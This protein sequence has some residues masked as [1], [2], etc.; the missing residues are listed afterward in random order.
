MALLVVTG[1]GG[2]IGRHFV[3]WCRSRG[4][5]LRT[6]GRAELATDTRDLY[7]GAAAVVH[8]AGRAHV[9]D[10]RE[11]D[12]AAAFRAVNLELTQRVF[13][14]SCAA[15]VRRFVYISS[16]G[17]LGNVSPTG[18]FG[19]DSPPAPYDYYSRSKYEAETWLLAQSASDV[20][21]VILRPPLVHGPGAGGNFGRL[22]RAA[23]RGIPLPTGALHARR[24]MIG[25]RNLCDITLTAAL[26]QRAI[27]ETF[28]VCDAQTS[29]VRELHRALRILFGRSGFV[30]AVPAWILSALLRAA[31]RGLDAARLTAPF[32]LHPA[33]VHKVF[34]WHPPYSLD[35][36]LEW[37]V[38][39]VRIGAD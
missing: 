18:G 10:E 32:E 12:P 9:L 8:F 1:A 23:R 5:E 15:Q 16:A 7:A 21:R 4:H 29:S 28:L 20:T 17:V 3:G 22:L 31:G 37:T 36:E 2:F 30:P 25:V 14:A 24:T 33:R 39:R 11:P 6:P 27:S 19:D 35:Q 13:S 34:G 26:D 38:A